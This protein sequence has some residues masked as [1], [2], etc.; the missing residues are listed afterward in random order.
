MARW[1]PGKKPETSNQWKLL[2]VFLYYTILSKYIFCNKFRVWDLDFLT[3]GDE[4]ESLSRNV[5]KVITTTHCLTSQKKAVLIYFA[6]EAWSHTSSKS[7]VPRTVEH[8]QGVETKS[9]RRPGRF[10]LMACLKLISV[11]YNLSELRFHVARCPSTTP[12]QFPQN[13]S[14]HFDSRWCHFRDS[15]F[16]RGVQSG[17]SLLRGLWLTGGGK[18]PCVTTSNQYCGCIVC[19]RTKHPCGSGAALL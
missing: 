11:A 6:A 15:F 13:S 9:V 12:R 14:Q 1:W 16:G 7:D 4:T 5:G 10:Q 19:K 3:F 8:C 17:V 18:M 2:M